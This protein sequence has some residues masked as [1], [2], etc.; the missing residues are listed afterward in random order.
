MLNYFQLCSNGSPFNGG[1]CGGDL[2]YDVYDSQI[3]VNPWL[4]LTPGQTYWLTLTNATDSLGGRDG[5]DID[6]GPS[7]AYHNLL[8]PFLLNHSRSSADSPPPLLERLLSPTASC[9]SVRASLWLLGL[10][11]RKLSL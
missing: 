7:Q 8:G 11:R 10:L 4:H 2:G 3:Q 1:I 6:S 9:C 5:W